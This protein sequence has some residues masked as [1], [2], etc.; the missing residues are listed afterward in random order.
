MRD[1]VIE[2]VRSR[3]DIL[4]ICGEHMSL[5]R[6]G[7]TYRGPC[8]LHGGEG[9]NFSID[10]SRGIFKCFVCGEGGDVF[11]FVMKLLGLDFPSAVRYVAERA[12]VPIPEDDE[13]REDPHAPVREAAAFAAEWFAARLADPEAGAPARE[14]LRGRGVDQE[15][16][17]EHGLGFAPDAWRSLRDAARARG[18]E[19]EVLLEAGLLA[20]SERAD[21]PYDRFRN[22]LVFPIRDLRDRPI[23][24]GGRDLSGEEGVPKYINSP[25]SPIFTKGRT[26]YLLDRARHAIRRRESALVVEGYMDALSLHV[27][28][29]DHAVAPLGTAL[30][31]EQAGLIVRYARKV[32][33]LY[34]SDRAGLRATFRTADALLA[35]GAEPMVVTLP[36]GEDPDSLV[37]KE[38]PGRLR[39]CLEDAVDALE[40]KLQIL[41]RRGYLETIDGRRRAV[42]ALLPTLRSVSDAALRDL[43]ISRAAERTGVRRETL[44]QELVRSG[45]GGSSGPGRP[46]RSSSAGKGEGGARPAAREGWRAAERNLLLL[47]IRDPSCVRRAREA[48]LAADDFRDERLAA[49]AR[50]LLASGGAGAG[51]E[52]GD[53]GSGEGK[54]AADRLEGPER[55]TL[56]EL[57][58]DATELTHPEDIFEHSLRRVLYRTR[59]ERL[60]EIDR[61]LELAESDQARELLRE[62]E[63]LARE[64]REAQVPVSFLRRFAE[65]P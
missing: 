64:L 65:A 26:L 58:A 16:A 28:G 9:P 14:Y 7:K 20:T 59:L 2:Q 18:M 35:A 52:G 55:E 3:A 62:K 50:A 37:R 39:E 38:G 53:E 63:A 13:E 17:E 36:E 29:M 48:G 33:L 60:D 49:V 4:E 46:R 41:E 22:R 25:E 47:F 32:F 11:G 42:D 56:R 23:G 1:E 51:T 44:V 15:V 8:P 54:T 40:R 12:G 24:F 61:A 31:G 57:E 19:D 10:P 5:K 21:E 43:Y 30:T 34:D 6:V 27:H 45:R